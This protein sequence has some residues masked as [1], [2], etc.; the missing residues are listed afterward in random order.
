MVKILLA[1]A[2]LL[3]SVTGCSVAGTTKG[4]T[5]HVGMAVTRS[6]V[7][8]RATLAWIRAACGGFRDLRHFCPVAAPAGSQSGVTLSMAVGTPRYPL[9][10]LQV[11]QGGEYFG[12]QRRN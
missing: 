5:E 11:E 6:P 9:N 8:L 7:P 10:L 3:G 2:V 1:A 4:G 12:S